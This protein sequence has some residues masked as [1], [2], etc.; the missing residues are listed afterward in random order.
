MRRF[1][2]GGSGYGCS[3]LASTAGFAGNGRC[4]ASVEFGFL[5]FQFRFFGQ[6]PGGWL[7]AGTLVRA[8]RIWRC[9]PLQTCISAA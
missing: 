6:I 7:F 9:K 2:I 8:D 4:P 1:H 3:D 5:G